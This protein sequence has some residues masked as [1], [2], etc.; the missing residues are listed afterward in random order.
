MAVTFCRVSILIK[1]YEAKSQ[2]KNK[3]KKKSVNKNAYL[4][5]W[6][7]AIQTRLAGGNSESQHEI[8]RFLIKVKIILALSR[9]SHFL[10]PQTGN[11]TTILLY[12]LLPR[13]RV[14]V[15]CVGDHP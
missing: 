5:F 7:V 6:L 15:N 2:A 3:K 14:E 4:L 11:L 1:I 8:Y 13:S 9:L 12:F 10:G